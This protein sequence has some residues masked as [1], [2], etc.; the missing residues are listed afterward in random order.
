[1]LIPPRPRLRASYLA[2]KTGL[3]TKAGEQNISKL[4]TTLLLPCLL[5][6]EM[7]G[8]ATWSSLKSYWPIPVWALAFQLL[9]LS[10][11]LGLKAT[12]VI[13]AAFVPSFVF[14]NVTSLPLL[15]IES[16]SA[17]GS[18]DGLAVDHES[19]SKLLKHG[20]VLFLCVR[21]QLSRLVWLCP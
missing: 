2:R 18:L 4:G 16:L 8:S 13:P 10:F 9:S 11:A 15:L 21:A 20:R 12:S 5:F 6:S 7:G 1:M 3:V 17:S 19:A 14:N